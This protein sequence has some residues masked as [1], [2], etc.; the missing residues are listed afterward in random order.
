MSV[1]YGE[2]V[3][4]ANESA[5]AT[6]DR[7]D[8]CSAP[9]WAPRASRRRPSWSRSRT[10]ARHDRLLPVRSRATR[11]HPAGG[12]RTAQ[13][14]AATRWPA[15][16]T[17]CSPACSWP[18]TSCCGT[19]PSPTSAPGWPP[20]SATCRCCSWPCLAWLVLRERPDRRYLVTLPVVLGGI[21]LV[22]GMLGG[23]A[24]GAASG[25]WGRIRP[26]HLRRLRVLPADLAQNGRAHAARG[27]ASWRTPPSAPRSARWCW[28]S[29]FG[30]LQLHHPLAVVRLAAH[31]GPAQRTR[32]AG[33]SSRRRCRGCP[34]RMSSL[35]LLL[36]PAG[37]LVL[38]DV[39]L[40]ERPTIVQVLGR[41]P[42]LRRAC[43]PRPGRP[44][45]DRAGPDRPASRTPASC[46]CTANRT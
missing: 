12:A 30:G 44:C 24:V 39:V 5:P 6:R 32:S 29:C 4:T 25:C 42:G 15:G 19:T 37:A 27:R 40:G 31:A 14:R 34:P 11:A 13:A 18:L 20:C 28:D 8:R 41:G 35:L 22:S 33:C 2:T 43:L 3:M 21:V 45:H 36:Q 17:Q 9:C 26:R 1:P 23:H 10:S 7:V 16:S 38:A 46:R